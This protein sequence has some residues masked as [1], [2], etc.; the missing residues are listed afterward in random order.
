MSMRGNALTTVLLLLL[1]QLAALTWPAYACGCGGMVTDPAERIAVSQE[2]S[3]VR[4]D[5]TTERIVMSLTVDG[6]A[7]EAAWIMPVPG[8]AEVALGDRDLFGALSTASDAEHRTRH[9]F[10]PRDG[11]WP[12]GS[13]GDGAVG[14]APEAPPR[15]GAPPVDVISRDR[16]GPFDVARLAATDPRALDGWLGENGFALPED[17]AAEL[18]PYVEREWEYVAIRLAPPEA[19]GD[20]AEEAVLGGTLDPISLTFASDEPVYPMRLS[21]LADT[22]QSLRIY[23][24]GPGRMEPADAIGGRAPEV[25]FAGRLPVEGQPEGPLRDLAAGETFLTVIDQ[26]FPDPS[27]IDADHTLER[28]AEDTEYRPVVFTDEL[29]TWAGVPAWIVTLLAAALLAAG[30]T[31]LALRRLAR[32]RRASALYGVHRA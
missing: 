26:E 16:L 10:W 29:R 5:G 2:T 6:D 4:W 27:A 9:Y 32:R 15:D 18:A 8:R 23:V 20:A 30:A 1:A 25:A 13:Q 11:D 24:L 21:R 19:G 12:R 14:G 3:A 28:A 7:G 31:A 22:P 17:L